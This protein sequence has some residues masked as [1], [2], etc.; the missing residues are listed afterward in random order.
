MRLGYDLTIE[1]TQKLTMTPEL[2]Q[3]IQILQFNSQ[4]LEEFVAREIM[5]NP[6]LD[7]DATV[8]SDG[9]DRYGEQEVSQTELLQKKEA[10]EAD[11]D[12]REKVVEAEYDDISYRQWEHRVS[13]DEVVSF[14]QYTSRDETLQ[15]YLLTQL[16]FSPLKDCERKIGRY[17]VEAIDENGYLTVET[18]KVA[19]AFKVKSEAVERILEVI[20]GFEPVGVGARSLEECLILQLRAKNLLEDSVEYIILHHLKDLGENRIQQIAKSTGLTVS[21]VQLVA[22]LIRTLDPK[23]GRAYSSGDQ[24]RYVVPDIIVEKQDT[25]Y[26]VLTNDGTIPHLMV[27]SYYMNLA[28][29]NRDDQEV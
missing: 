29:N 27:S 4:E 22:D 1:Q 17:L 5:E 7:M 6:V 26:I 15:D 10:E 28:K 19:A 25:G 20:Q 18:D 12:L 3:A 23:P 16:S 9:A 14:D 11:F 24:V 2:I 21:Q 8:R 13:N